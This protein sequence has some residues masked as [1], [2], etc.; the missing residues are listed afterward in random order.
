MKK[1]AKRMKII[2]LSDV[3][4]LGKKGEIKN[5]SA[6]YARNFLLAKQLAVVATAAKISEYEQKQQAETK[7]LAKTGRLARESLAKLS[8]LVLTFANL[9]SEDKKLY[10]S[11]GKKE[12]IAKVLKSA[13]IKLKE[14]QIT[15]KKPLK[16]KGEYEIEF[17]LTDKVKGNFKVIIK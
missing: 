12:V 7:Q 11:V 4:S 3:K 15:L 10:G 6:G 5:V 9:S 13:K 17:M 14:S 8:A 16:E 1:R 2:L